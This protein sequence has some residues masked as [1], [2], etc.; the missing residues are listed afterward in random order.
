MNYL[1]AELKEG[2]K[3][4]DSSTGM[5]L[6]PGILHYFGTYPKGRQYV[7]A[8]QHNIQRM[9]LNLLN[10]LLTKT[11]NLP[12]IIQV[13]AVINILKMGADFGLFRIK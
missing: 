10:R 6:M 8:V 5:A 12:F 7:Y 9:K 13:L 4:F 2:D 11:N 1:K 3:I